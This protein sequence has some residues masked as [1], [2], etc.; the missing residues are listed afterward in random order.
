MPGMMDTVLNLGLNDQTVEALARRS[1]DRRFAYDTY[2]RF[3]QMYGDVVLGVPALRNL[4][5]PGQ[6]M[7]ASFNRWQIGN[8]YGAFGSMTKERIEVTVQGTRDP[9]PDHAD[10][11]EY[12][13]R[14]KPGD[15]MRRSR[16]FAPYHLR[17]DWLMWFLPLG[18]V[19]ERWFHAFL[20]KLLEAD[21][22]VLALLRVDPF[23]GE[24]PAAIRVLKHRYR[25]A[26]RAE[27]RET[28]AWWVRDHEREV[29]PPVS[30]RR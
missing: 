10:W 6:L 8:A 15:V 12:Q 9:D 2:R 1:S 16:Q 4:F 29:I 20:G 21:P 19:H 17:L 14:G 27:H 26:T 24:R 11:K 7:N 18:T 25:Y 13:F 23:D 3:I 28:G 30:L 22:A 5:S